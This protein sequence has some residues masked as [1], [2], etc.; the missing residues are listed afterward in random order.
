VIASSLRKKLE[1]R[2]YN[3]FVTVRSHSG[4]ETATGRAPVTTAERVDQENLIQRP[5]RL[6]APFIVELRSVK[7]QSDIR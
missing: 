4:R 1:R 6:Y 5:E 7:R 2:F 3:I